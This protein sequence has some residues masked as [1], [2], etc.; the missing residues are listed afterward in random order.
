MTFKADK[1]TVNATKMRIVN[2][3]NNDYMNATEIQA[4][5]MPVRVR[6]EHRRGLWHELL[7]ELP[8]GCLRFQGHRW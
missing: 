7:G 2:T 1:G 6:E 8:G 3:V 5:V 4:F